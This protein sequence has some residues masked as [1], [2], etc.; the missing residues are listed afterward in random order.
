MAD[1]DRTYLSQYGTDTL[2]LVVTVAGTKTDPD[3]N[4][5]SVII[6][7][8][9]SQ[10]TVASLMATRIDVG[11]YTVTLTSDQTSIAGNYSVLWAYDIQGSPVTYT[12]YLVIGGSSP[13][14]DQLPTEMK[15]IVELTWMRMSDMFDSPQ[16]GPNLAAYWQTNFNRGRLAQLLQLAVMR[17]NTVSQPFQTYTIDGV[18]GSQFPVAQWGGLL[19]RALWVETVK[20]L[21]RSYLEQPD[22]VGGGGITRQDRKDYMD[23]WG[24]ILE[25]E[26]RDLKG[27]L[28]TFK[29]ANMGLGRAAALVSGGVYG[30]FNGY[31]VAGMAGRPRWYYANY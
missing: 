12:T 10:A 26:E 29:I 19:E 23:R 14:Y 11:T 24:E 8:E 22:L 7:N 21:R 28:D 2:G 5:V 13:A 9:A 20:H 30:R 25:D 4:A 6:Q 18:G 3:S 17:L 31:R 1:V 16:A 27:Q 15:D